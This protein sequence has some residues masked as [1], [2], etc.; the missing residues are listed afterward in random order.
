MFANVK[1]PKY[2]TCIAFKFS[3]IYFVVAFNFAQV[4]GIG[5]IILKWFD[6]GRI[7]PEI[8]LGKK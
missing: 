6:Q 8:S 3:R 5:K 4:E 1:R 2:H 7:F